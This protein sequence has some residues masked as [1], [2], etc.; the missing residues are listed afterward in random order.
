MPE[1][2]YTVEIKASPESV[3]DLISNVE[4]FVFY[5]KYIT[6][7]KKIGPDTYHWTF[8]VAGLS[9]E[10]D[11]VVTENLRPRRVAWQSINGF[12]NSGYYTL[13]PSE[14][15]TKLILVMEYH[16]QVKIL[17]KAMSI[18]SDVFIEKMEVEILNRVKKRLEGKEKPFST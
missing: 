2:S 9:L 14:L 1:I 17:E 4:D 7:I 6:S 3:H 12:N 16:F 5:S 8:H 13:I 15:G 11:S 10:W 18:L